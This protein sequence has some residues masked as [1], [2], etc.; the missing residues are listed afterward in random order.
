MAALS[1]Q[2][3]LIGAWL[4]DLQR[5]VRDA[6]QWAAAGGLEAAGLDALAPDV[7]PRTLSR[8]GRRELA[9]RSQ[10]SGLVW[11]ALRADVGGR[12]LADAG[13]LDGHLARLRDACE[14]ARDLRAP[15]V[16]IPLGFIPPAGEASAESVRRTLAEAVQA[17][18]ALGGTLGVRPAVLAGGEPAR[19]LADFLKAHDASGLI[20]VDLHPGGFVSRGQDPLAAMSALAPRVG[21][22]TAADYYRGGGETSFGRGDVPW[23]QVLV[24]LSTLPGQGP[25][26]LLAA[27][28]REGDRPKALGAAVERLKQLRANPLG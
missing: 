1:S 18:V 25:I 3:L 8:T 21:L 2:R 23:G 4:D 24:G 7:N 10:A 16:V 9:H 22:A 15:R 5:S 28:T 12:R 6:L 26:P 14:L 20:E 13:T 27:C 19:D 17:L 11:A